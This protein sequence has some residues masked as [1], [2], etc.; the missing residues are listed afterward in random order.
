MAAEAGDLRSAD[1]AFFADGV[2]AFTHAVDAK[3]RADAPALA[4]PICEG[5]LAIE[6]AFIDED[7]AEAALQA[8]RIDAA[9]RAAA[10]LFG[11]T[12]ACPGRRTAADA[13]PHPVRL[14]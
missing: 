2:H 7:A 3:L 1:E 12:A 8:R 9:L 13:D 11:V 4:R 6:E 10:P 14:P 5:V